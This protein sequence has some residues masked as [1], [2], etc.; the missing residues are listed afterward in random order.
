M[1]LKSA[2]FKCD[3]ITFNIRLSWRFHLNYETFFPQ[4]N[5]SLLARKCLINH[6][7]NVEDFN[8]IWHI[9]L[10]FQCGKCFHDNDESIADIA[11]IIFTNFI[12]IKRFF[13]LCILSSLVHFF[14]KYLVPT[15]FDSALSIGAY[16]IAGFV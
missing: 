4:T 14:R 10:S 12:F 3:A 8:C 2:E 15:L 7:M 11:H 13:F 1:E 16:D 5:T 9:Y 6:K